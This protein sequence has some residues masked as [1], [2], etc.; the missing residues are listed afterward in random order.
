[1]SSLYK[2]LEFSD[3]ARQI[4]LLR[5]EPSPTG[6]DEYAFSLEVHDFQENSRPSYIAI[7]YTWGLPIP[8]LPVVI[9]GLRMQVRFNC[10]YALWQM[11]H[12][13]YTS[14]VN[15]W[16]DSLCINQD[17]NEEKGHQVAMMGDI[18]SSASLVA[19]S[20]GSGESLGNVRQI[21]ASRSDYEIGKL[22]ERFDRLPYFNRVWIIQEIV[23]A[24]DIAIYYGFERL[25]WSELVQTVSS[26][27]TKAGVSQSEVSDSTDNSP[28]F[29]NRVNDSTIHERPEGMSISTQLCNHRSQVAKTSTIMELIAKYR[30]AEASVAA[31]KIYALFSLVPQSD[32][33]RQNLPVIYGQST[34][35]PLFRDLV[36][37]MYICYED[38]PVGSKH[39]ALSL[40]R[41][42]GKIHGLD[43][44]VIAFLESQ[45]CCPSNAR[46]FHQESA[47]VTVS[48]LTPPYEGG[49]DRGLIVISQLEPV[50]TIE[51]LGLFEHDGH[52]DQERGGNRTH[53]KVNMP[54]QLKS[55]RILYTMKRPQSKKYKYGKIFKDFVTQAHDYYPESL[56]PDEEFLVNYDVRPGDL[57]GY[58]G[59]DATEYD[60]KDKWAVAH[61]VLRRISVTVENK[62]EDCD[63]PL[64]NETRRD[65]TQFF[66]HSWAVPI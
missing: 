39:T 28:T 26:I 35:F 37:L 40:I 66:L 6:T 30:T 46:F 58:L 8:K 12:H 56:I 19:A 45:A 65:R 54:P 57:L 36:K 9:N 51:D 32:P 62:T 52:R 25:S 61:V 5:L 34:W 50:K 13:G 10:W 24:R 33:I 59:W 3:P 15:F 55:L 41:D 29:G 43:E 53:P 48:G 23:L 17:N 11:R 21:L 38:E 7:S 2:H 64:G 42:V 49:G 22:R 60:T 44:E 27:K 47:P 63:M 20:L 31:D 14:D 4:R 1:M 16:M 18:Y